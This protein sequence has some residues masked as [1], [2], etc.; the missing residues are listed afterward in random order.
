[1]YRRNKKWS[2]ALDILKEQRLWKEAIET[3]AISQDTKVVHDLLSYFV[4]TGN[5]EAFVALLYT[6]YNL[7]KYDFVLEVSWLNS[8]EDFIKP[9][10]ISVKKEQ[11]AAVEKL[12][13]EFAKKNNTSDDREG[14]PLMLMNSS[15]H[16]QATGF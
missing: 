14:Q 2:K 3:A 10:E 15:M 11:N 16:P 8:L 4:D 7:I 5:R 1:M 13:E 6:A 9:Y 12:S